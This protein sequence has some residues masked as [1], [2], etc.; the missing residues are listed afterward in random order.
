MLRPLPVGAP[1][2]HLG[3]CSAFV[4]SATHVA[5]SCRSYRQ[6]LLLKKKKKCSNFSERKL[7]LS[8]T[9]MSRNDIPLV[10]IK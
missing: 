6:Y 5:L 4:R 9:K 8:V 3:R 2:E 7:K 10:T 1:A